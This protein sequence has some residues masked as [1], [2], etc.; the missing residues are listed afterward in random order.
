MFI[1]CLFI[2]CTCGAKNPT[3]CFHNCVINKYISFFLCSFHFTRRL[4]DQI[5][6]FAVDMK[7][8]KF[9]HIDAEESNV[10][11]CCGEL[12]TIYKVDHSIYIQISFSRLLEL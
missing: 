9:E 11:P 2:Y 7:S 6:K 1:V 3:H 12:F 4:S 8:Y 10:V 5:E